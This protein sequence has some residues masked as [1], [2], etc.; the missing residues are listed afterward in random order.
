M[1]EPIDATAATD[2]ESDDDNLNLSEAEI[3]LVDQ[4][5]LLQ[6]REINATVFGDMCD[7]LKTTP[8]DDGLTT[9]MRTWPED[10]QD[11]FWR[12]FADITDALA[13]TARE[14]S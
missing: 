3:E 9:G 6:N 4:G 5:V 8:G 2:A 13:R 10:A 12:L 1:S 14:L 11:A 7:M